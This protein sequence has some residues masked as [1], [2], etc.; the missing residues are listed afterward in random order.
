MKHNV[1]ILLL[2]FSFLSFSQ[3]KT[4]SEEE[5]TISEWIDGTLL[6]PNAIDKPNLAII[7][8]DSGPTNRDGNQNFLK[9][10]VLGKSPS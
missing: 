8:A 4:Y 1:L 7:I 6:K 3:D 2:S 9:K 5:V 10:L